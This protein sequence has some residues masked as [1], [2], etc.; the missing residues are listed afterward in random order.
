MRACCKA[1]R[2]IVFRSIHTAEVATFTARL[3]SGA[4]DSHAKTIRW[5][6]RDF[7]PTGVQNSVH[8]KSSQTYG[9]PL[10]S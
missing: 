2:V 9:A 5:A 7:R 8:F 4:D 1:Q 3:K 6:R 10:A